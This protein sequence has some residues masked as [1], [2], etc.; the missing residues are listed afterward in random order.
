MDRRTILALVLSVGIYYTWLAIRGPQLEAERVEREAETAGQV[1][2]V[3]RSESPPP[4]PVVPPPAAG[5][6]VE[7]EAPEREVPV[8]FCGA[9]GTYSTVYGLRGVTLTD[10]QGPYDVQPLYS[11]VW[12]K[13]TG[14]VEGAWHP[15]GEHEPGP[16]EVLSPEA[17]AFL[18][19]AGPGP[20]EPGAARMRVVEQSPARLVVEGRSSRGITVRQVF[21]ES[22]IEDQCVIDLQVT[23][24]NESGATYDDGLWLAV[25]DNAHG[26]GGGMTARYSSQRQPTAVTDGDLHY[27]GPNAA[28]CVSS[29]TRL[30][31]EADERTFELEGPVSWYGM[32]D[33]YFGMYLVPSQPSIGQAWLTRMGEGE[34]ALDGSQLELSEPLAPGDSKTASFQVYVGPNHMAALDVVHEDLYRVVDLGFFAFFGQVLLWMLRLFYSAVGNW[35]L[36]IVMVTVVIKVLFFPMTQRSFRSMQKMQKIQPELNRIREELADNPQEMNKKIFEVMQEHQVNPAAGCLPMIV[37]MPVWFA[38]YNVLLTSVDLYHTE[39][40][41]LKDLTQPDPYLVLPLMIMGFMFLQQQFTTPSASMPPEQQQIMR[42][43]PLMFGLLFFAF[44]SGLA[45]Y[46]FVNMVLSIL[47]QWLIKRSLDN[48]GPAAPAGTTASS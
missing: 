29:G 38:L 34:A 41:Y 17:R 13:I 30:G 23:W 42:L 16:A 15:W 2:Q 10:H 47:Q 9:Q 45:V 6:E 26:G 43:M 33:R 20:A 37:Q 1:E 27:G 4:T 39:F 35:G 19:G 22:R 5:P 18:A 21:E 36:A 11:W 46:V 12:G 44:P 8:A 40:L 31:D 24:R 7:T 3:A 25:H 14:S 48:E 28:G 32:S